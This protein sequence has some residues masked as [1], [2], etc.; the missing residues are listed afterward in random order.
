MKQGTTVIFNEEYID[1]LTRHRDIAQRK[2][3]TENLPKEKEQARRNL[4]RLENLLDKAICYQGTVQE[5]K[6]TDIPSLTVV[7]TM[8]GGEYS[9][10]DLQVI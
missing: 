7:K 2:F 6:Y 8:D 1:T 9:L 10:K 3:D 4:E 5:I